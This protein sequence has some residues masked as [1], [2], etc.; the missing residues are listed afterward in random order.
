MKIETREVSGQI[1]LQIEG[2]LAGAFVPELERC[3]Q[4]AGAER[5]G[6][7]IA[8]DLKG[9]TCVD[10]SGRRLLQSMRAQGVD[11]LRAGMAI[12]DLLDCQV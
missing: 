10:R 2:R 6:R 4:S 11:L 1:V 8:L 3:W 12:Q 7:K 9:V 5:P